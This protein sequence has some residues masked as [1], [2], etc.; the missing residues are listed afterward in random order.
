METPTGSSERSM[1][2]KDNLLKKN[3]AS[4]H[5][6]LTPSPSMEVGQV[7]TNPKFINLINVTVP[8]SSRS[9]GRILNKI[10]IFKNPSGQ[11]Q[12][13]QVDA[14]IAPCMSFF[15]KNRAYTHGM[16]LNYISLQLIKGPTA[17]HLETDK[18]NREAA[19]WD[20]T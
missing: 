17:K 3:R 20:C 12:K 19:K 14:S 13:D 2:E 10:V 9:K 8:S 18:V 5:L 16:Y 15:T 4:K 11:L 1:H 6:R 7:S